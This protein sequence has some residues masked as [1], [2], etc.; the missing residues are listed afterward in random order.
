[1]VILQNA[2][3]L[4]SGSVSKICNK[5]SFSARKPK[6]VEIASFKVAF[7]PGVDNTGFFFLQKICEIINYSIK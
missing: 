3:I 6:I 7:P 4:E 1:M 5:L 2:R